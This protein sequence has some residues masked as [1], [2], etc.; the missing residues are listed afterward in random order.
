MTRRAPRGVSLI[1][2]LIAVSLL[3]LLSV[4][5]LTALHVGLKAVEKVN[6]KLASNRRAASV[7]RILENQISGLMPV[8]A[9]CQAGGARAAFFAG[10]SQS[11]RFASTYSLQEAGRGYPR[12]LEFSVIP[13]DR[14]EG[15]RL[16]VNER[17]YSGPRSAGVNCTGFSGDFGPSAPVFAPVE[18]GPTSF[19]LADHLKYCRFLYMERM[20]PPEHS[21][22]NP[23]WHSTM[24]WPAAVKI[25]LAPLVADPTRVPLTSL[26]V[27]IYV[28]KRPGG[29]Y[30]DNFNDAPNE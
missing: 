22:W 29:R 3:S 20:P 19:V 2:L 13:G 11:M 16:I 23:F 28:T 26:T 27:P 21:R 25:D 15:V 1:E 5:M 6:A 17:L 24:A 10:D 9:E 8:M 12:I 14:N 4:G 7:Q 30:E 18:P